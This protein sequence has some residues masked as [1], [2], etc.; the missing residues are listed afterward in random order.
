M[1]TKQ[2]QKVFLTAVKLKLSKLEGRDLT[3]D[4]V[5]GMA[6]IE[7]RALKTYR[8]PESSADY[9]AMPPV[10]EAAIKGLLE[11]RAN[12]TPVTEEASPLDSLLVPALAA[13]VM[14]Q[15]RGSLIEGRMIAGSSRSYPT[16]ATRA[17]RA[18]FRTR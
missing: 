11:R 5:A 4:E 2:P 8:V 12:P 1:A 6:G 14:R 13:L 16:R 18:L 10:V 15:A 7:P 3:W 17:R 9:R